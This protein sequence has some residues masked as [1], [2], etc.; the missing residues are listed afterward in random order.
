M[1]KVLLSIALATALFTTVSCDKETGPTTQEYNDALQSIESYQQTVSDL[2]LRTT[3]QAKLINSLQNENENLR[4][5][6]QNVYDSYV[7]CL[8]GE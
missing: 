2:S 4:I 7:R 3:A 8:N 5:A 6:Y 1:K